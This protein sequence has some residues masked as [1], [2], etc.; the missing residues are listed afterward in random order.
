MAEIDGKGEEKKGGEDCQGGEERRV[1][2]LF[3]KE[4]KGGKQR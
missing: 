1:R 2:R 4:G 3:E